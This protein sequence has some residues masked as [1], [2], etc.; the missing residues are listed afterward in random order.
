MEAS[1]SLRLRFL[2]G[3]EQ[4]FTQSRQVAKK[5]EALPQKRQDIKEGEGWEIL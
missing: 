5:E 2:R 1:F 3:L 4:I